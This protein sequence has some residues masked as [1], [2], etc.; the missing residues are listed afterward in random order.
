ML[1]HGTEGAVYELPRGRVLKVNVTSTGQAITKI[2]RR[3]KG[4]RWAAQIHASGRLHPPGR[5][6]RGFWYVSD[7]LYPVSS[8]ERRI[9]D[10]LGLALMAHAKKRITD[11]QLSGVWHR[12]LPLLHGGLR[13]TLRRARA[14]G[15]HD[16]HGRNVMKTAGGSYKVIDVESLRPLRRAR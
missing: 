6:P 4:K 9:L 1:G 14:A 8:E 7:R 16:L 13:E 11:R 10:Q 5:S 12:L 2:A 3:V 15:Y